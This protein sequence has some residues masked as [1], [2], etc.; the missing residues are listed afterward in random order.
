MSEQVDIEESWL[1]ETRD[2]EILISIDK[3]QTKSA[4]WLASFRPDDDIESFEAFTTVSAAKAWL[5]DVF[6][7]FTGEER[8]RL[9]WVQVSEWEY[10]ANCIKLASGK[11]K[12]YKI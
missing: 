6:N 7:Q 4:G 10:K 2:Q 1:M 5:V 12:F 3:R 8:K 9:P 11:V